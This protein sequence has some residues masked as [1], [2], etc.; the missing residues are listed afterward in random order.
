MVLNIRMRQIRA[1]VYEIMYNNVVY[2]R[3]FATG[4]EA[5]QWL[6]TKILQEFSEE[7]QCLEEI[8]EM[9]E[10]T[11]LLRDHAIRERFE[12]LLELKDEL[13]EASSNDYAV[14]E[15]ILEDISLVTREITRLIEVNFL[16]KAEREK[17]Q[18]T[19][20]RRDN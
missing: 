5:Y 2:T 14:T 19:V 12:L 13:S 17:V 1:G 3:E 6:K 9:V 18:Y 7:L 10:N 16:G 11:G 4:E 15:S 8:E 20:R